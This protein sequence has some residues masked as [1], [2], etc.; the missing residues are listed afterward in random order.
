MHS[1]ASTPKTGNSAS[2]IYTCSID[3]SGRNL[4][5]FTRVVAFVVLTMVIFFPSFIP[6]CSLRPALEN[7]PNKFYLAR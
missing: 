4:I 6:L 5:R 7:L 2:T 1:A 3:S